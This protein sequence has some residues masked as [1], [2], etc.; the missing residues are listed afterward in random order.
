V[1]IRCF[2]TSWRL[3]ILAITSIAP[4][5]QITRVYA[6]WS[7]FIN[8]Q[9]WAALGDASSVATQ[10]IG[11]IRTVRAFG[12]EHLE[13]KNYLRATTEAVSKGIQDGYV[14]A[15]TYALTSYLD[16]GML[17]H[18]YLILS[19][20]YPNILMVLALCRYWCIVIMVW[21]YIGNETK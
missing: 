20:Y 18:S 15:G 2:F 10:A 6:K 5:I 1:T 8:R 9:I 14:G 3:S 11:N 12:T 21:R 4:I 7:Q 17:R 19:T 13:I 16:L